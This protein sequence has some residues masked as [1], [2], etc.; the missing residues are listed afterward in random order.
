MDKK[1][2]KPTPPPAA[3]QLNAENQQAARRLATQ[4]SV[5]KQLFADASAELA[6][7]QA[8][9]GQLMQRLQAAQQM[10]EKL[11]ADDT[12]T[13]KV[14]KEQA[15]IIEKLTVDLV[16]ARKAVDEQSENTEPEAK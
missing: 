4:H 2:K 15:E 8:E 5:L 10:I 6:I 7:V 13:R 3:P 12:E 9:N 16:E 1:N 14:N 11:T